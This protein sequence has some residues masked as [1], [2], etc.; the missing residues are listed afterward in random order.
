MPCAESLVRRQALR[1]AC[2]SPILGTRQTVAE[3]ARREIRKRFGFS[4]AA[5]ASQTLVA[6]RAPRAGFRP[7][8]GVRRSAASRRRRAVVGQFRSRRR[9][10]GSS[11]RRTAGPGLM[12]TPPMP[13]R[14]DR[15][16]RRCCRAQPR[17]GC[18]RTGRSGPV[19]S[20]I[21]KVS[22]QLFG[23][24]GKNSASERAGG[25]RGLEHDDPD[26]AHRVLAP[27][28]PQSRASA[29]DCRCRCRRSGSCA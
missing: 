7:G 2:G 20:L 11:G 5:R 22:P 29:S 15:S 18:Q 13:C 3:A 26:I 21:M 6:D 14:S 12:N 9:P 17:Q 8:A 27:S 28:G 25:V 23:R 1:S 16:R 24:P 19:S 10:A 4:T